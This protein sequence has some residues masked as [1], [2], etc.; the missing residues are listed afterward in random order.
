MFGQKILKLILNW[1]FSIFTSYSVLVNK[2]EL[3]YILPGS[4]IAIAI[5]HLINLKLYL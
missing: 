1:K 5:M 4:A 2:Q 3:K